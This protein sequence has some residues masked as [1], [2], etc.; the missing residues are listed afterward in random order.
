[1]RVARLVTLLLTAALAAPATAAAH[2]GLTQRQNLPIPE[3]MFAWAAA[4]VLML[5]F[6]ALA[7]LWPRP[8]LETAPWRPLPWGAGRVLGSRVVE[9]ACGAIGVALLALVIVG[10]YVGPDAGA[11][12]LAPTFIL[13]V[14]WVGL[15][16]ASLLFGDVFRA[17]NPW[18][19]IGRAFGALLRSRRPAPTP[20][21]DSLGRWPTAVVLVIF[22]WIELVGR[23]DSTP[24]TLAGAALGYTVITVAAQSVWGT[25]TWSRRGEGFSVYFNLFS[26]MSVFETRDRVVGVRPPLGGLPVLDPV[27]GTVAVVSVMIG[28]VTFDGVSQGATWSSAAPH[29]HDLFTSLGSGPG[30]ADKLSGTLGLLACVGLVAGFY[31]IGIEGARTVGGGM[32]GRRLRRAFAHS[33]VPIAAAYVLAHYLTY[34]LFDGQRIRYLASDPFGQGW[35][36]FGTSTAG[37][38]YSLLSQNGAW[39]LEVAFVVLGHVA[40]LALAHDRALALYRDA[41]QA[42]MSQL[43]MLGVMIGFTLLALWLLSQAGK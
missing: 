24:R 25:E 18:R 36:L 34:L 19:A 15:V 33:L 22:T 37:I 31:W 29:L 20:Y 17:F 38:D 3:V 8:L 4:A 26:R 11:D 9:V 14:F 32:T 7:V 43:W 40:A 30:A 12:N 21:P 6:V 27:P 2:S 23:W 5:S 1:V 35:D 41:K 16:F 42:V 10:G 39:Y 13:I 28:T